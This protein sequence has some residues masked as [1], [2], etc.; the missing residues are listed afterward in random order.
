MKGKTVLNKCLWTILTIAVSL[1][2]FQECAAAWEQRPI[3][4]GP[5]FTYFASMVPMWMPEM[6][7]AVLFCSFWLLT[8]LG[9]VRSFLGQNWF[10][11][12]EKISLRTTKRIIWITCVLLLGTVVAG[13]AYAEHSQ[14]HRVIQDMAESI[15]DGVHY[16]LAL[17][18]F[19]S[20][21]ILGEQLCQQKKCSRRDI[22]KMR[23]WITVTALLLYLICVNISCV[24]M[25]Y[26]PLEFVDCLNELEDYYLWWFCFFNAV[27][28]APLCFFS[29]RKAIRIYKGPQWLVLS[30]KI[31]KVIAILAAVTFAG[32][33]VWNVKEYMDCLSWRALCEVPEYADAVEMKHT[34]R[35]L[36]SGTG[37]FYALYIFVKQA[38]ATKKKQNLAE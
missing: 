30:E 12:T 15:L 13:A 9:F 18:L 38:R 11:I 2:F 6:K 35:A 34:F 5:S 23:I 1:I 17:V 36:L 27:F 3:H 10:P 20:V 14:A 25:W 28:C 24:D 8:L 16:L 33:L 21:Q 32:L 22:W 7:Q 26:I 37:L 19:Y 31:P 29:A 4:Q